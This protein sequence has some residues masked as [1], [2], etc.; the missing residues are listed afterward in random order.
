MKI[1]RN[2]EEHQN[3]CCAVNYLRLIYPDVSFYAIPNGGLRNIRVAAKLKKEGVQ[4]GVPDLCI[5][6]ARHGYHGLYI[7]MKAKGGSVKK[8]QKEWIEKLIKEN[9]KVVV[10]WSID[11]VMHELDKYLKG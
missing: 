3:Q 9:Y 10:C 8:N 4:S 6:R 5:C 7:E 1:K 11:D 2:D